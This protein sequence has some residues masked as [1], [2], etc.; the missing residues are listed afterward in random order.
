MLRHTPQCYHLIRKIDKL[1]E[2]FRV[3]R[4]FP[5]N[6]RVVVVAVVAVG[7]VVVVTYVVLAAVVGLVAVVVAVAALVLDVVIVIVTVAVVV[8]DKYQFTKFDRKM[9]VSNF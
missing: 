2:N 4:F 1:S 8:C 5:H 9:E 7:D 3:R 6:R